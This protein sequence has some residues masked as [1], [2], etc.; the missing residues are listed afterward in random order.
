MIERKQLP[1]TQ[2]VPSAPWEI[3]VAAVQAEAIRRVASAANARG[4]GTRRRAA[5]ARTL[6]LPGLDSSET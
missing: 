5:D 3:P 6:K 2:A 1:A 4:Q